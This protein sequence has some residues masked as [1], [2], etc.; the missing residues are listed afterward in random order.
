MVPGV[1][2]PVQQRGSARLELDWSAWTGPLS[3]V[4]VRSCSSAEAGALGTSPAEIADEE[5]RS[6]ARGC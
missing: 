6:E 2:P 5:T 3:L 1:G 4:P